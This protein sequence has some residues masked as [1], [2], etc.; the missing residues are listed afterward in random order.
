LLLFQAGTTFPVCCFLNGSRIEMAMGEAHT[1][2]GR[3]KG[4]DIVVERVWQSDL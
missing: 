3:N 2:F 4:G 1:K